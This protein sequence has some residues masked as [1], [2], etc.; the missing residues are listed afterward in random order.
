MFKLA[1]V[2]V[3]ALL[4]LT[5][6]LRIIISCLGSVMDSGGGERGKLYEKQQQEK[7]TDEEELMKKADSLLAN[8]PAPK[9]TATLSKLAPKTI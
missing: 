8:S 6:K 3:L 5:I 7:E 4:L 2:K 1:S 9:E